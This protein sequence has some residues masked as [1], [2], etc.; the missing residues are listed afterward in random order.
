MPLQAD[1]ENIRRKIRDNMRNVL[2]RM[3]ESAIEHA[4]LAKQI[5]PPDADPEK[6]KIYTKEYFDER[7]NGDYS[8]YF[9]IFNLEI[10]RLFNK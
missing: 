9:T 5:W 8:Y 3:E 10:D 2:I 6:I 4:K 1:E 7:Y